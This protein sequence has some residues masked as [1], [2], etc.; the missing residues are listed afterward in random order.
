MSSSRRGAVPEGKGTTGKRV[1][2]ETGS[3]AGPV[4]K[5]TPHHQLL[6]FP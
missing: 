6:Q 2:R 5:V 3:S 1:W 4:P